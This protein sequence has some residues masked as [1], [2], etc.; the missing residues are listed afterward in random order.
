MDEAELSSALNQRRLR[1]E[2]RR[3]GLIE[4]VWNLA[5]IL[6]VGFRRNP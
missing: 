1:L 6:R 3:K 2:H 5:E 4:I